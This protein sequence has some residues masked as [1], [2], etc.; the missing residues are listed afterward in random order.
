MYRFDDGLLWVHSGDF[1]SQAGDI[2]EIRISIPGDARYRAPARVA[3]ATVAALGL[4]FL[5][6]WER[7]Q[8]RNV[9]RIFTHSIRATV[10]HKSDSGKV[11]MDLPLLD[12]SAGGLRAIEEGELCMEDVIRCRLK[13]RD[14]ERLELFARV[15][16]VGEFIQDRGPQRFVALEFIHVEEQERNILLSWV[17]KEQE[18][19]HLDSSAVG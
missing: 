7:I 15:V 14:G 11:H 2:V 13:Y 9:P 4:R 10:I 17:H 5:G 18:R 6:P 12:I 8:T 19:G 3:S 1:V 16:R